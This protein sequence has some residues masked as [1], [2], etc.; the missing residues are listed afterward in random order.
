M[1]CPQ[2]RLF[3]GN[4]ICAVCRTWDRARGI[5]RSGGLSGRHES[6]VLQVLRTAVGELSD[7]AESGATAG[8]VAPKEETRGHTSG[9]PEEKKPKE[10]PKSERPEVKEESEESYSYE[11]DEGDE[12]PAGGSGA[13]KREEPPAKAARIP[14]RSPGGP[15]ALPRGSASTAIGLKAAGKASATPVI[16]PAFG[17]ASRGEP[18]GGP[19]HHGEARRGSGE[20]PEGGDR[21]ER[22]ASSGREPIGRRHPKAKKRRG[23]KGKK[24]RERGHKRAE[25]RK[26]R[27]RQREEPKR[28]REG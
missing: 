8:A 17:G 5:I 28:K 1:V 14:G 10:E 24:W 7:L 9:P 26:E 16:R 3:E 13:V 6:A 2:C 25:D 20:R 23:T 22:S 11:E 18:R 12:P 27:W 21:E 15:A 4:P 19:H